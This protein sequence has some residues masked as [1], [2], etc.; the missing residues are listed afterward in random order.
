SLLCRF[1]GPFLPF[2]CG[3]VVVGG[4]GVAPAPTP[5]PVVVVGGTVSP[6]GAAPLRL[7]RRP[8]GE[9]GVGR[10]GVVGVDVSAGRRCGARARAR[11]PSARPPSG[12]SRST[13]G[14][15]RR[16]T[17]RRRCAQ[18]PARSPPPRR[19]PPPSLR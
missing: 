6:W 1:L 14:C 11:P 8:P 16:G 15:R 4:H 10:A 9:G 7:S 3:D 12:A 18:S 19:C 5:A 2:V 17:T 13:R